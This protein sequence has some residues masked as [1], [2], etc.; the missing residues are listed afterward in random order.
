MNKFKTTATLFLFLSFVSSSFSQEKLFVEG[1]SIED[2]NFV[3]WF[4][5]DADLWDELLDVGYRVDRYDLKP[6]GKIV[7]SSK[8]SWGE[9]PAPLLPN[10]SLWFVEHKGDEEG[11]MEV[12]GALLYDS[13]FQFEANDKMDPVEMRYNFIV[14]EV[15]ERAYIAV[16]M[17][18]MIVDSALQENQAYRYV[19]S[20]GDDSQELAEVDL[21][22]KQGRFTN[23]PGFKKEFEFPDG[24]SL[25]D[26]AASGPK[27]AIPTVI[28]IAKAY[29]DSIVLR[30][31]PN[32]PRL[33]SDANKNGYVIERVVREGAGDGGEQFFGP[34]KPWP[35]EQITAAIEHDSMA[36]MA[37]SNLYSKETGGAQTYDDKAALFENRWGFSLFAAEQS[38]LAGDI[39]GLRYVDREVV[40]GNTYIYF[41]TTEGVDIYNSGFVEIVNEYVAD[42]PPIEFTVLPGDQVLHLTWEKSQNESLFSAY[43]LERSEDGGST[44][45]KRTNKPLVFVENDQVPLTEFVFSDSVE[46][47]YKEYQY[48]LYGYNSFGDM[49]RPAEAKGEARD[50]TPPAQTGIPEV[51]YNDTLMEVSIK[52]TSEQV[53]DDFEGFNILM[54]RDVEGLYDTIG[55]VVDGNLR[56]YVYRPGEQLSGN[57]SY[58]FKVEAFDKYGNANRSLPKFLNVPDLIAP[59]PPADIQGRI[60]EEGLVELF[61]EHSISEDIKGYWVYFANDSTDEFSPLNNEILYTNTYSYNIE[62]KSTNETI[63]YVVTSEDQSNNRGFSTDILELKRPDLVPPA[64]AFML[65]PEA[66]DGRI[67]ITWKPSGSKDATFYLLERRLYGGG[68]QW[69]NIDSIPADQSLI[70]EDTTWVLDVDY[71]YR[72]Q[73]ADDVWNLS[74]FSAPVKMRYPFDHQKALVIDLKASYVADSS[75]VQLEWDFQELG[76]FLPDDDYSFSIYKSAGNYNVSYLQDVPSEEKTFLDKEI[77]QGVVYNYAVQIHFNGGKSGEMSSPKSVLAQ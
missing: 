53:P 5:L 51:S 66:E 21:F 60:S 26:M 56:E 49:S 4:P 23:M 36:M 47:N 33:W 27:E 6:N 71:E 10:D 61:W 28:A 18:M 16:A 24:Y 35:E 40:P 25:S 34:I 42:P 22:P 64:P 2:G 1:L 67:K 70:Y 11:I 69:S 77:V 58:Y 19:I 74:S 17:G 75:Y 31:A 45:Q 65:A 3:K 13:T 9:L 57:R 39:L 59:E 68:D 14:N 41:V 32:T 62:P 12:V 15:A 38:D 72:V 7:R 43:E 63:Y 20:S 48:R 29:G 54:G 52:W 44:W 37:A 50:M 30:W 46:T 73:V 8:L 76:R 55:L